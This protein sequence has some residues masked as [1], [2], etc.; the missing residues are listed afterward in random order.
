MLKPAISNQ[1]KD[2]RK[3]G[4]RAANGTLKS[5]SEGAER[6]TP[7]EKFAARVQELIDHVGS[8]ERLSDISGVS[9]RMIQ[10]Y[11]NKTADPSRERL[12]ALARA[13]RVSLEW[14]ATG[15]GAMEA[16]AFEAE[17]PPGEG[18]VALPRFSVQAAAGVG[19]PVLSEDVV[20]WLYFKAEWLR[21]K[22][23]VNPAHLA[24]IEAVGDSMFPT[25]KDGDILVV[26][27]GDPTFHGLGIYVLRLDDVLMVKR[28]AIGQRGQLAITSD[29]AQY[30]GSPIELDRKDLQDFQIVGRVVWAGGR[31]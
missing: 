10:R 29:N 22:L 25:I 27:V 2:L 4:H 7:D 16:R 26:N 30:N 1:H 9:T 20:D 31:M 28:I 11:K 23:G 24:V 3:K 15:G 6:D 18:Y 13:G 17:A 19:L 8:L 14:L 5:R 12:V 21:N